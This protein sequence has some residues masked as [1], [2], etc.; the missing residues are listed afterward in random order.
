MYI[1]TFSHQNSIHKQEICMEFWC[2]NLLESI[3]LIDKD[4]IWFRRKFRMVKSVIRERVNVLWRENWPMLSF[5]TLL[6]F[7]GYLGSH[8]PSVAVVPVMISM[9]QGEQITP[10]HRCWNC[11]TSYA[12]KEESI[13]RDTDQ[14]FSYLNLRGLRLNTF[15]L[16]KYRCRFKYPEPVKSIPHVKSLFKSLLLFRC[17]GLAKE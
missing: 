3:Y 2:G 5:F 13:Q 7:H 1:Y 17:L 12:A 4:V 9:D 15:H 8:D 6:H 16:E 14:I 11:P 10:T